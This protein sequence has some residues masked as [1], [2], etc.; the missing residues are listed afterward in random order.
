M[1]ILWTMLSKLSDNVG[2][3]S[4]GGDRHK[5]IYRLITKKNKK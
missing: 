1:L 5:T 3:L 4:S 2:L